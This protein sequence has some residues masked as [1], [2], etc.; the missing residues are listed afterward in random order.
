M[1]EQTLKTP[2]PYFG[3]KRQIAAL[4]WSRLGN[5]DNVIEPFAGSLAVLLLR[6]DPPRVETVNDVD[7]MVANF[8]RATRHDPEGVAE[9]ADGPVNEADLH[10]RHRWLVLS[11]HAAE[12]RRRMR[13]EPLYF[14]SRIAGSWCWGL[15]CWIGSGWCDA[16]QFERH[17][18]QRVAGK[19]SGV[20]N[21]LPEKRPQISGSGRGTKYGDGVHAGSPATLGTCAARREWLLAWFGRL[22]DR[23]RQVRVCC[24]DW[25]RVCSSESTTTHLGLTGVY[26]D[27]PYP[28]RTRG[29]KSRTGKIYAT[30][31][32]AKTP[33]QIRDE[34]LAWCR[35]HGANPM[36]RVVVSGYEGDGY[37]ALE[38]LGWRCEWWAAPG[39][40]G[41][42]TATGKANAKRE[43]LWS[44]PHCLWSP[45]LFDN[46][47]A[48]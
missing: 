12:F 13:S 28:R 27:P 15:C 42:M 34:V 37:E 23:L 4:V 3:G 1:T 48:V 16:S 6:P 46:L 18:N 33:E 35:E 8:W 2:F 38:P 30:D 29:K 32:A 39:G 21:D 14:D 31:G 11:D 43:R 26:L 19:L 40:Y 25:S 44:S 41:N 47:E 10:A 9:H 24:G 36:M 17:E 45:G 20:H 5:P 22:R 7:C